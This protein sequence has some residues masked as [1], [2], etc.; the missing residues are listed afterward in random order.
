LPFIHFECDKMKSIL[1]KE[2]AW[3]NTIILWIMWIRRYI[4][5]QLHT[6]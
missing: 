5:I 6:R 1:L 4:N 3:L 2:F